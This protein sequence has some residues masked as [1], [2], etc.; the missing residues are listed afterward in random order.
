MKKTLF[1]TIILPVL[2][3]FL[4]CTLSLCC[5]GVKINWSEYTSDAILELRAVRI[6]AALVVGAS[7]SLAGMIF[8]A[9]LRNALAEPFTLGVS[10]GASVGA[11]LAIILQLH[12]FTA[13]AIPFMALAGALLILLAVLFMAG[14]KGAESIL[15]SGVIA[16]TCASS[17]LMYLVSIANWHDLAGVTW[18]MLGDLQAVDGRLLMFSA[19]VLAAATV[20]VLFTARE[21]NAAAMGDKYGWSMGVNVRLFRVIFIVAGSL[22]AAQTVAMAGLIAFVGLIIPHIVRKFY[23]SD[24]RRNILPAVLWGG[25]FLIIC[26][27]LSR[28]IHPQHEMPIGVL[29]AALGGGMFIYILNRRRNMV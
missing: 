10:G 29:T 20:F 21:L 7:L 5:G 11:A 4:A 23:G 9:V 12:L 18:W 13:L 25:I 16:G 19:A 14:G 1:Y 17:A 27:W 28:I 15:L 22:L 2:L 3:L 8:Q 6:M 24:H 26:D